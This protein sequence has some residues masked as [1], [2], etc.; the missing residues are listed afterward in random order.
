VDETNNQQKHVLFRKLSAYFDGPLQGRKIAVWG[1]SFKPR[2]DDIREAPSLVLIRNLLEAGCTVSV[3][4]PVAQENVRQEI[5]DVVQYCPHHY[6]A[7]D[8]ADALCIVTEWN[9][10]RNP[11]F[12]YIRHKMKTPVIF[13]GRNLYDRRRMA[14]RGFYYTGIGLSALPVASGDQ[15]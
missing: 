4:D 15:Q 7:C 14:D 3:H 12:D 6:D 5:G 2:T 9:E 13:D 10:F 11:D 1:L 8:G